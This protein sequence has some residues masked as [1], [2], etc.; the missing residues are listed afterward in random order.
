MCS[1]SNSSTDVGPSKIYG[2]V[3]R[4]HQFHRQR[5]VCCASVAGNASIRGSHHSLRSEAE[6]ILPG[7][8][9]LAR[10]SWSASRGGA[11]SIVEAED[12]YRYSVVSG[13]RNGCDHDGGYGY[14]DYGEDELPS[15]LRFRW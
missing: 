4:I 1:T 2:L 9:D 6:I 14:C 11:C 7:S 3:R 5:D 13:Q 10:Y 15:R 8:N 12:F